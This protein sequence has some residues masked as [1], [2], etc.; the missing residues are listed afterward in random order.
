MFVEI[1]PK[2]RTIQQTV[3]KFQWLQTGRNHLS[4]LSDSH[5][6]PT[7]TPKTFCYL[8]LPLARK[9]KRK[10]RKK[11][12]TD[13]LYLSFRVYPNKRAWK[14]ERIKLN[15]NNNQLRCVI[16]ATHTHSRT[17]APS[18]M[19]TRRHTSTHTHTRTL[20][21]FEIY[22][23]LCVYIYQFD[24][25]EITF[26]PIAVAKS[27]GTLALAVATISHRTLTLAQQEFQTTNR[28]H[29]TI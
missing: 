22:V 18:Y 25:K 6:R 24:M 28:I 20:Y 26:F 13:V 17:L 4:G 10:N 23:Y 2:L 29:Y 1:L 16:N 21:Y 15:N 3:R 27:Q 7:L 14:L 9:T 19:R 12:A 11:N 5:N 8:F